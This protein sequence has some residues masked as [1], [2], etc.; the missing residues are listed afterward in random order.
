MLRTPALAARLPLLLCLGGCPAEQLGVDV[1]R[2]GVDS[3]S[4]EDLQ[5]DVFLFE[6]PQLPGERSP[7][8]AGAPVAAQRLQD[9]LQQMHLLPAFGAGYSLPVP[10]VDGEE[11]AAL[12]CGRRDGA[13]SEG[14]VV[15]A[16]DEGKG[17]RAGAL[18]LAAAIS[19]AKAFDVPAKPAQTVVIC[20]GPAAG[21]LAAYAAN[22]ALPAE[23]TRAL[24]VLG[25]VDDGPLVEEPG[26]AVGGLQSVR[27]RAQAEPDVEDRADDLDYRRVVGTVQA[28]YEVVV[29]RMQ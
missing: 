26:P 27:L 15:I 1:P 22:P 24:I 6:D 25:P 7:G 21:A 11:G 10:T 8:K 29:G 23:R 17:A 4:Q 20:G 3:I 9:R 28:L 14:V 19:L 2:G 12:V 18:P 16:L 5:R 13:G